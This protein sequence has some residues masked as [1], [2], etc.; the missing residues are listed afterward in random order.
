MTGRLAVGWT[1]VLLFFVTFCSILRKALKSYF[2]S[3]PS[4]QTGKVCLKYLNCGWYVVK[5]GFTCFDRYYKI[6]TLFWAWSPL[7]SLR[8]PRYWRKVHAS[9][10]NNGWM[11]LTLKPAIIFQS[12]MSV[13]QPALLFFGDV[14][15]T[16][17][18]VICKQ[19]TSGC[20]VLV[21][22]LS[23]KKGKDRIKTFG[24]QPTDTISS[25]CVQKQAKQMSNNF[26]WPL[27]DFYCLPP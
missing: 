15:I 18:L 23:R 2:S 19:D 9:L 17:I 8:S 3:G 21:R 25:S 10:N 27:I 24:W 26:V 11:W 13:S 16:V 4:P 20:W 7:R 14:M 5:T 12:F 6:L 1:L 22:W